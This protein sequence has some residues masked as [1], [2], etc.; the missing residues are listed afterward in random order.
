LLRSKG[1][2]DYQVPN[3]VSWTWSKQ[4]C[5][6]QDFEA[7]PQSTSQ[8]LELQPTYAPLTASCQAL[9]QIN[10][11][12]ASETHKEAAGLGHGNHGSGNPARESFPP[13][14]AF[15]FICRLPSSLYVQEGIRIEMC[16]R[17]LTRIYSR[18]PRRNVCRHAP[19][20]IP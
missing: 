12:T 4:P 18:N 14:I 5:F 15:S 6:R 19:A 10:T 20:R 9:L 8:F 7:W 2:L 11:M 16:P 13:T 1:W 3:P 17:R